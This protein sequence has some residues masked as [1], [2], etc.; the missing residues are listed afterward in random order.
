MTPSKIFNRIRN[1]KVYLLKSYL[2]DMLSMLL[3]CIALIKMNWHLSID[4][5]LFK[6]ITFTIIGVINGMVVASLLHNTSHSNVPTKI[7]NRMVGEYCGYYVLYGF[8]S[9][10]LVH[11]LHHQ[12]SDEELDP[13]NPKGMSFFIFLTAPMRYMIRTTKKY[14]NSVHGKK[15]NYSSI[16]ISQTVIFHL[17]LIL[18]LGIWYLLLGKF[19][20][21][22][23]FIPTFITII[24]VFAHIN[25]NCHEQ[26][27]DG[28][29]EIMNLDHNFYYKVVNFFT[30]GGYYHKNH[31]LNVKLFN[32]KYLVIKKA[33]YKSKAQSSLLINLTPN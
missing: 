16:M 11:I 25:Y 20:F 18:R 9:F 7:L 4:G 6:A 21:L 32:P 8:T 19:L 30:M 5:S 3:L 31:H 2:L 23:F 15:K 24:S 22:A 10:C 29:I 1:E 13:V 14:L 28:S 33:L 27:E 26:R 17:N 12:H